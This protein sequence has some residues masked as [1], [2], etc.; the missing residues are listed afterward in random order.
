MARNF[1]PFPDPKKGK[2]RSVLK[3]PAKSKTKAWK[4]VPYVR[5][6]HAIQ[7]QRMD[8]VAWKR[9]IGDFLMASDNALVKLLQAD[10]LLPDWSGSK[11]PR[12]QRGKLSRLQAKAGEGMPKHRC[13]YYGCNAW[14]NPHHLHPIFAEACGSG[15]TSLQTQS[16]LL[17]LLLN[18]VPNASIHRILH[19]NH[20]VIEDMEKRLMQLRKAWVEEKEKLIVFGNGKT[21][22]D[23]EAD[24]ATFNSTDLKDLA[25]DS[26]KPVIWEQWSGIVQRGRPDTLLL[27]RLQPNMSAKR[28]PGPGAIRKVEWRPLAKK[29]LKD[30]CV[31]LHTDAAKSYRLRMPGVLHD[32]V[33][34]C[35][36]R[37]KIKGKWVWKAPTYVKMSVHKDP[38]TGCQ[39]KTKGGT[40]IVD[41]AWRYLKERI[42][43]NQNCAVGSPLMRA[44]VRSAQYEYW[45]RNQ[46]LWVASGT[47][48]AWHMAKIVA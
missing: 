37:Q 26:N 36:K 38:K 48:C 47:L 41:R 27:H 5:D 3:R 4:A 7:T 15:H 24:E 23:I 9:K 30:R 14:I 1:N 19:T 6:K 2:G 40:Q 10:H 21:W 42:K 16:A 17:F 46:D 8:R 39:I 28:A 34:H 35:K 31:I 43:L 45:H 18:R 22:T 25:E 13:N 20:K 11:C 33:R 32:H 12:C 44:K 29:H